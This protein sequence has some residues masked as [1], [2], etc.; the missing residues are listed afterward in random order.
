MAGKEKIVREEAVGDEGE[1][2]EES[3]GERNGEALGDPAAPSSPGLA[4][5]LFRW[6]VPGPASWSATFHLF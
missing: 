4:P 1:E 3:G 5:S 2:L 6:L